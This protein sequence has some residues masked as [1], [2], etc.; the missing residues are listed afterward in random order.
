MSKLVSLSNEAYSTLLKMKGNDLS[1]SDVIMGLISGAGP[2]RDFL[3]FAGSLKSESRELE[4][5]K[6]EIMEDRERNVNEA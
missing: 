5:L 6:K 4:K 2:R 1:F 3:K